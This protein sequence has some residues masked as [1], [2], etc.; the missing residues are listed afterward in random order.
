MIGRVIALALA[1]VLAAA[2][3]NVNPVPTSTPGASA[4]PVAHTPAPTGAPTSPGPTSDASAS[5]APSGEPTSPP[6]SMDPELAAQIHAV[7]ASVPAV[8]ELAPTTDVPFE[9]ITRDQFREDLLELIYEDVSPEVLAAEERLL[10]RLGLLEPDADIEALT[11]ELYG[12]QV[13]AYYQPENGRFYIIERDQPFGPS[14]KIVVAHEY[15]HALQ[16]QHFDLSTITLS[17]PSETDAILGQLAV[18]EGDASLAS[19]L[20]ATSNL[21][22]DELFQLLMDALGSLDDLNMEGIPLVM[23]RQL[24]FPYGEGLTFVSDLYESGGYAAVDAA[25]QTPPESTE[26]IL[27]PEKYDADEIPVD[28]QAPD[29]LAALG[30]GWSQAYEQTMGE[31]GIQILATGG[32]EP[33]ILIPGLPVDWPH[34][35]VAAGWGGDRLRMYENT[36][37]QWVIAWVT[38]WDS[39]SDQYE[40]HVRM[41]ELAG[42]FA[43]PSSTFKTQLQV[44]NMLV[45]AIASDDVTLAAVTNL[46]SDCC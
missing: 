22:S 32:E 14:D 45:T 38:A 33:D 8:R 6:A 20:W 23:R 13:A 15:T 39:A 36:S 44:D 34:Q 27:H 24:E 29:I 31:L 30:N 16:D 18:I 42:T 1:L 19:Q 9:F 11:L 17:D 12:A 3:V 35:E 21:T 5:P 10:K 37:G 40:F 46:S 41:T 2:C 43:G 4:T 25:I 7:I 28:V 26:Q